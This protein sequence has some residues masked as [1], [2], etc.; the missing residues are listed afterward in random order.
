MDVVAVG[1]LALDDVET[2]F[3]KV[4]NALGG[5]GVYFSIAASFFAKCGVISVIGSDFPAEHLNILASRGIDLEGVE[6]AGGRTFHW[7]GV[8]E[9]DM[10]VAR[11][12]KTDLNVLET[13][14]P[15]IP[16]E[17]R[18]CSFLF[19]ANID[20]EI[21]LKVL[22]KIKPEHSLCDTMNYWITSK[23]DE[24]TE[25][26]SQVDGI[27]IN[28]EEAR[29]YCNTPN[30]IKAG[31]MMR[32]LGDS[33]VI[34][35]KGEHGALFFGEEGFFG[36]PGFPIEN[37]VDP[38]GAGDSFAGGCIGHLA[39]H[40]SFTDEYVKKSIVCGSVVASFVVEDF[41]INGVRD[42]TN[43]HIEE[44]YYLLRDIVAFD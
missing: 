18:K 36:V 12:L 20:P 4:S 37:V 11:T 44:R 28:E 22:K 5:S 10:N 19:L 38:T 16:K 1:T 43:R 15:K 2:P 26:F 30:L 39:K 9:Y 42:K 31:W 13:F 6:K 24:L 27:I 32:E 34:I 23:R 35:K 25:V 33:R 41:S 14:K 29:Q 3:G 8:Y 17:Y 21:Q 40:N 7:R